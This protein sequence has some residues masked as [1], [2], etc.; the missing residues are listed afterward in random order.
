MLTIE[1]PQV[2]DVRFDLYL[3][4]FLLVGLIAGGRSSIWGAIP[5]ALIFVILRSYLS[6][7]FDELSISNGSVNDAQLVGVISGALLIVFA[8]LLPGGVIEGIKNL[9]R[10]YLHV[11]H[12][13]VDGWEQFRLEPLTDAS[14]PSGTSPGSPLPHPSGLPD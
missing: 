7:W 1:T 6:T 5:G 10:P 4:I 2:A 12:R 8:F 3:S 11:I 13:P 14:A 9:V